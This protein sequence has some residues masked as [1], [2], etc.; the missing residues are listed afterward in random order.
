MICWLPL[1]RSQFDIS[2]QGD[3]YAAFCI[4]SDFGFRTTSI[5]SCFLHTEAFQAAKGTDQQTGDLDLQAVQLCRGARVKVCRGKGDGSH[6]SEMQRRRLELGRRRLSQCSVIIRHREFAVTIWTTK[7]IIHN[8]M[9]KVSTFPSWAELF[10][11]RL[12]G[13]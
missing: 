12:N 10:C 2:I 4:D 7:H 9:G 1:L 6:L 8:V 5:C 3:Q 13:M 11:K